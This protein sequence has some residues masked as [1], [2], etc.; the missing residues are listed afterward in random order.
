MEQAVGA[1]LVIYRECIDPTSL[2][3]AVRS[4]VGITA[5]PARSTPYSG[6]RQLD[7]PQPL[8]PVPLTFVTGPQIGARLRTRIGRELRRLWAA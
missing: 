6:L 4:G 8:T 3:S 1:D 5:L 7:A 2:L